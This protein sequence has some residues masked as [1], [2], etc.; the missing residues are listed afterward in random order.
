MLEKFN[1]QPDSLI[2]RSIQRFVGVLDILGSAG[3]VVSQASVM[4]N[5]P[6]TKTIHFSI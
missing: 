4:V 2:N 3:L 1:V 6:L 5:H